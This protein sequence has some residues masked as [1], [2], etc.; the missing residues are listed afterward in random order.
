MIPIISLILA[1]RSMSQRMSGGWSRLGSEGREMLQKTCHGY[2]YNVP[3]GTLFHTLSG[4]S[5][6]SNKKDG[7]PRR[8][9][10]AFDS[11]RGFAN[12][13]DFKFQI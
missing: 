4:F 12:Q 11:K 1:D 2:F 8:H 3:T 9:G 6:Q 10:G 13:A 5:R 7:S